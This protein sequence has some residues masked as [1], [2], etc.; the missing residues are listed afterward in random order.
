MS[1]FETPTETKHHVVFLEAANAPFP[2]FSFPH[3]S[4]RHAHTQP[5]EV[6]ARI[7]DAT[8]LVVGVIAITAEHLGQAPL[9][10]CMAITA[11]GCE[12]LD[13]AA[14]AKRGITV[15][16]CPQSNVEAVGEH[17]LALYFSARKKVV[18]VHNA[19][20]GPDRQWVQDGSLVPLWKQGPP[21]SCQQET[22]GIIGYGALGRNIES[23][24]KSVGF[25]RVL[26][27]ERK[28]ESKARDGRVSFEDVIRLA[29]TIVVCCPKEPETLGLISELE[30]NAMKREA[31]LLN[32]SRGG[33]VCEQALAT[34]LKKG[35]IFGAATDVLETEP[36][37]V[38]TTPLMPDIANGEEPVPNLTISSHL[39]WFSQKTVEN[40]DRLLKL[41]IEGFVLDT[42]LD[43]SSKPT[44]MVHKG[45]IFR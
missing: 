1:Q 11:T 24:A 42:L 8:I 41:G 26:I 30:F 37:G 21:L 31:L 45:E 40:L 12:W 27:G 29:T 9:L 20:T 35:Q 14:F 36:G 16:N 39:A 3:T 15:V 18:Q 19:I 28:G 17:F 33:V 38:G 25:G 2:T 13:R 7:K 23:L 44:V 32:L 10:Q 5:H 6:A 4:R 22:L 34:A 43:P